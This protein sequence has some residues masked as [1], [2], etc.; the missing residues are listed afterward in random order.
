[1]ANIAESSSVALSLRVMHRYKEN[2]AIIVC[3]QNFGIRLVQPSVP[4]QWYLL[5]K[6]RNLMGFHLSGSTIYV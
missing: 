1:M 5:A 3:G 2:I 6:G 4:I